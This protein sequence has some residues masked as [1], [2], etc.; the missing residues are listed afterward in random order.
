[1]GSQIIIFGGISF[2]DEDTGS[3][4]T[5]ETEV[6]DFETKKIETIAPMLSQ[7]KYFGIALYFVDDPEFCVE[8]SDKT[9][10]FMVSENVVKNFL[11][12]LIKLKISLI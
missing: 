3:K 1:M 2:Y 10:Q 9:P 4:D 6:W 7:E 8:K 11:K 5:I 12:S